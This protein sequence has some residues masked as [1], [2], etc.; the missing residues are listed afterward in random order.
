[1]RGLALFLA[2]ASGCAGR[3]IV[4]IE[5]GPSGTGARTTV[6]STVES[7]TIPVIN[8][9]K[10]KKVFWECG[11]SGGGLVC[12]QVCD[13]KDDEGDILACQKLTVF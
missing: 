13:V 5:D 11:E 1:M 2:L 7:F 4:S 10:A 9:N 12:K 3:T 6:I 8:F